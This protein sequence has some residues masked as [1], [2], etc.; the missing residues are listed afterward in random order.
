MISVEQRRYNRQIAYWLLACAA[1]IF[2]MIVLGGVTRLTHS[3]L[4]MVEWRPILGIIPPL[5]HA[6]WLDVFEKYKQFPEYQKINYGMSLDEFKYIFMYE[7]LHRVLGRIIGLIYFIPMVYFFV[8]KK[9]APGFKRKLLTLFVMGGLQGLMGWYMVMSGLVDNPRVSQYRLTA[10]LGLAV[11]IYAY[12]LWLAMDLLL[13]PVKGRIH[14]N[15]ARFSKILVGFVY[16][17]I[18]TGGLVAGIRAGFAYNTW[19]LMGEWFFPPG[20]FPEQLGFYAIFEDITTVQFNHRM[21]AYFLTVCIAIFVYKGTT[22][23]MLSGKAHTAMFLLLV[24]LIF[25]VG[26][27]I[28]TLIYLVPVPLAAAHQA[29][30]VVL[31]TAA[32]YVAHRLSDVRQWRSTF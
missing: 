13:E 12:M 19:P 7:Y 3:G 18:L 1:V 31:L 8:T 26:L 20:L 10:H 27:G 16:F 17:M 22:A 28:S 15:I 11:L 24:A 21:F 29:G 25:Q 2:G 32:L 4:S 6:D 9:V 23:R 5:S 14:N 30:A